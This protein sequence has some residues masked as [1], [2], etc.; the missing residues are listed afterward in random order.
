MVCWNTFFEA[1][2]WWNSEVF[3]DIYMIIYWKH[4]RFLADSHLSDANIK[5]LY[6]MDS[7]TLL[8]FKAIL[9]G[10]RQIIREVKRKR[11][12]KIHTFICASENVAC[13]ISYS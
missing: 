11:R 9:S 3:W 10:A 13:F 1:N 2:G 5:R 6:I 12:I 4:V 8:L 7:T